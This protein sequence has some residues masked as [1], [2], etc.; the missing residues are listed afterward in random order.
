M[1]LKR[2]SRFALSLLAILS[3]MMTPELS[4]ARHPQAPTV[5]RLGVLEQS[6][7]MS[8]KDA[9][10]DYHGYTIDM[11]RAMCDRLSWQCELVPSSIGQFISDLRSGSIDVAAMSLLA[12]KE[13][14]EHVLFA[15]PFYTSITVFYGKP[16]SLPSQPN[17]TVAVVKG[18][19]QARYAHGNKWR[20]LEV[21]NN[22]DL[23]A[24]VKS[25][26]ADGMLAPMMTVINASRDQELAAMSLVAT[27]VQSPELTGATSFAVRPDKPEIKAAMDAALEYLEISGVYDRI[28]SKYVP[29]R[30]N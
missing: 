19:A 1:S 22:G 17:V 12:T 20:V 30:V 3:C 29:F 21:T 28:N 16:Q 18:S 5:V 4:E 14:Q 27:H 6:P 10:G 25:G 7:P 24:A 13:R 2:H 11:A 23:A 9:N 26:Q 15:R 8:W